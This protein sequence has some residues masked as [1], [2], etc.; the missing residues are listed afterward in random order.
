MNG[1][2]RSRR[3]IQLAQLL[4]IASVTSAVSLQD[5]QAISIIQVPSL[6]CLAAYGNRISGCSRSDFQDGAQCSASCAQGIQQEQSN[7]IASC[8]NIEV[9]AKSLLGLAL[10]GGLLD[11]LCPGLQ[12]TSVT[13]IVAPTTTRTFLTPSQTQ[14]TSTSTIRTIE[15]SSTITTSTS[16]SS[17]SPATTTQIIPTETDTPVVS[18]T[19]TETSDTT[20]TPS[21][22]TPSPTQT[23][24]NQDDS[25]DRGSSGGGSP[26]DTVFAGS[27]QSISQMSASVLA[28][29]MGTL[30]TAF[31]VG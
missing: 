8:N 25:S 14:E 4:T 5:F 12:A 21:A 23:A 17:E 9:N 1:Y 6:S 22:S 11:A 16:G 26:F 28:A 27:A 19:P 3:L 24:D 31:L 13:S 15:S 18:A 10:E 7:I 30:I 2:R 29:F 20:T